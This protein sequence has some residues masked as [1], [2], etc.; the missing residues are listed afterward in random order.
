M[1]KELRL[2]ASDENLPVVLEQVE[3]LLVQDGCD[4]MVQMQI[5]MAAEEL[6]VNI[7]HYAYEGQ[8]GEAVIKLRFL[9]NPHRFC[10][11]FRDKGVPYNPLEHEDP[12]ITLSAEDRQIGGLGIYLIKQ[13]MDSIEYAYEEGENVLKIE[14][15]LE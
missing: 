2:A 6:F 11:V 13:T 5:V 9:E 10:M 7:A 8:P 12:D 14:K 3:E 1:E 15:L 4:A